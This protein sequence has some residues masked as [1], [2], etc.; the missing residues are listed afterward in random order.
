MRGQA[1]VIVNPIAG[2]GMGRRRLPELER[3]L[4][5]NRIDYELECT[6]APLHAAEIAERS[7]EEGYGVVVAVGGDG[8]SNEVLNGLMSAKEKGADIPAMGILSVG[9]GNDFAFGAGIPTTLAEGCVVLAVGNR[10]EM[11]VGKV[12]GGDYPDGRYFGN[13]IGI[14]FD[15]IVG[16][17][18][19]KMEWAHG[20]LAY[21]LGA[22]KTLFL[23]YDAPLTSI[24]FGET[25]LEQKSIQISV[26]NGRRMGGA[27]YM[28]PEAGND[29]GLF[30]LCITGNPKRIEILGIMAQYM[31]GTQATNPHV[32]VGRADSITV[33]ALEG[34]LV[35]HTDGEIICTEGKSIA[36]Q[37]LPRQVQMICSSERR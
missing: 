32:F 17:E 15:T 16:I 21:V 6:E 24:D 11:D 25:P 8:T 1:K 20:F 34:F 19:A 31:K 10:R 13:G 9:R 3:L 12:V 4:K 26:M 2:K 30:D 14:G 7:V 23:Y 22:L 35:V 28:A 36:A 18:A 33:K 37:C 27:F 29:D 5:D